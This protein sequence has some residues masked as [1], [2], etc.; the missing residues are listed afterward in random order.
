M[1]PAPRVPARTF[2]EQ[3]KLY[4]YVKENY[5]PSIV[6]I[7]VCYACLMKSADMDKSRTLD[8][9]WKRHCSVLMNLRGA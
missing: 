2:A 7:Y 6:E 9:L 8:E 5:E 3:W 1:T 4:G